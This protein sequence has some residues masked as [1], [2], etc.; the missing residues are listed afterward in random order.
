MTI[1]KIAHLGDYHI[2]NQQWHERYEVG[3]QFIYKTLEE[4][5][6]DR[7][8]I[9]GDLFEN[10]IQISNEAKAFAGTFL[11]K[12]AEIAPVII[13]PGNH[14]IRKKDL[15]RK[16]SVQTVIELI[17]NPKVAYYDKSGFYA[18][19]NIVWVN[20]SH[21]EKDINPWN[22]I[23]HKRDKNKTYI[24][25]WHDPVN[26]CLSDN[27]FQMTSKSYRNI[28]DFKGDFGFFADIHKFQY[29]NDK[30]T[31]AY[32]SS[33]FQQTM[34][35]DVEKH[36]FIV[37]DIVNKTSDFIIVPDEY[38]LI[39]FRTNENYDYDNIDFFNPFATSKSDFRVIWKDYSANINNENEEKIKKYISSKWNDSIRFE[40]E[41][42]YT[43]V[44]NSQK[45]TES[46][47]INDKQV[48]Q[49]IFREYLIAN[50]Y[51]ETFIEEILKVDNI[52]N[53]RLEVTNKINNIDWTID[54]IWVDN[55]KSY[56]NFELDWSNI[57]GIIQIGGENQQGKTTLLDAITYITHGTTLATNKLGGAQREKN[58]DNR[59]I[60]NK[61]NLDYCEGGMVINVNG[62][63][64]TLLRRTERK[65]TRDKKSISSCSTNLE[66]YEGPVVSEDKKLRDERKTQTQQ[67]IDSIIGDFEDF[68]RMT[69]TNSENLNYLISL[70][71]ATFIDSVIRDAG[72]DIFEKKLEE[73]KEYKKQISTERIDINLNDAEEEVKG[74]KDLLQ[75]HKQEHDEFKKEIT[76]ID[77]KLKVVSVDRDNEIK[78]LN[79]IDDEIANIDIESAKNKI[80]EYKKA[81]E[82]NL[83]QQKTNS[84][85]QKGLRK[86]YDKEKYES[87]IKD[88]K[89]IEDD[90]LSL[91]LEISQEENKI[92]KEKSNMVRVDDKVKSLKQKEI[93]AQK[94]KL[95]II[96]NDIEKISSEL[97][98]YIENKKR[99]I[100]DQQKTQDF[101]IKTLSTEIKNIK[102]KGLGLKEQI[103]LLEESE[104]CPTCGA[105]P[106]HQ[107]HKTDKI[108][109]L[110]KEIQNLL[111][112]G[113]DAQ[114]KLNDA[115]TNAEKIQ[116]KL[117]NLESGIYSKDIKDIEKNIKDKLEEKKVEIEQINN[118]CEEIKNNNFENVPELKSNIDM[119][120]KIK[121]TS[122]TSLKTSEETI[123]NIRQSIKDKEIKKSDVQ[124]KVSKIEKIKEEVKIYETLVQEN[125]EL[126]L[127]IENIK[128]TIENAKTKIDKYYEQLKY[129]DENKVIEIVINS[130]D[131][132]L[133][134]LN[135]EKNE[136]TERL[137]DV[138][139]EAAMTKQTIQD[140]QT[141]IKKYQEQVKRDEILKE[142]MKCVHRDGLSSYLLQKSKDLINV[143]L[144]DILLNTD[145]TIFFDEFLNLKM[146]MRNAP[147]AIQNCLEGSG[148]ERTFA[149]IALKIA[150]RTINNSSKPNLMMLDEVMAKLKG[151]S[152][153]QFNDLLINLKNKI[154]KILIIEHVH[155]VPYDVLIE[156]E[157][158]KEGIS[159]LILN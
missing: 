53:E 88:I 122:E 31:I 7:I 8:V 32:C 126:V 115:K 135:G 73:F 56:D 15:K 24:D 50:K 111:D 84:E 95:I 18:D 2:H 158:N 129:I 131:E 13:V 59:Y 6:P 83:S 67:K 33:T 144:D 52:I 136:Y 66:Y 5:S 132:K 25:L 93:D 87:L 58:A 128:L 109:E 55:F 12:L 48:Q 103:K 51:D 23:Q 34:G 26:G 42:I 14:D 4:Q 45:L 133:S 35:E 121:T 86:E 99:D 152:I 98:S 44:T 43:N 3:N 36:G 77:E 142:Y 28:A 156:V 153:K 85:K 63:L 134:G 154:D 27:G 92:E 49:D 21:L 123:K 138:M 81:I 97:D 107:K 29:L 80:D 41:R 159:S 19:D 118:I 62:E 106:E 11:N 16:N 143:E 39:T 130:F 151:E 89:K 96:N 17:N 102:E 140:I 114:S 10:F 101:K 30:E 146:Y 46:I 147:F 37:W 60:N 74:L 82:N 108:A 65:M 75:T 70:D 148:K 69:L 155:E 47:N 113:K 38:K 139:K 120:L 9:V 22:D 157:K 104:S 68:I 119:G 127:K 64:Y 90:I 71:R 76:S 94:A 54:K 110:Q 141:R 105:L 124:D 40:K 112:K 137:A 1:K 20:H 57:K 150:L 72:Y 79:K 116:R 100:K 117:E 61:R 125:K 78:K 149:A 91:K 145:F